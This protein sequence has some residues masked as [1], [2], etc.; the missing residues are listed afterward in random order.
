MLV[1]HNFCRTAPDGE[2]RVLF[3]FLEMEGSYFIYISDVKHVGDFE[4]LHVGMPP[5][6][7]MLLDRKLSHA[8]SSTGG[9]HP[10]N[11]PPCTRSSSLLLA[12]YNFNSQ[13]NDL[14]NKVAGADGCDAPL[15]EKELGASLAKLSV[16]DET[17]EQDGLVLVEM[18]KQNAQQEGTSTSAA[19][20]SIQAEVFPQP[21]SCLMGSL[22]GQG[23]NLASQLAL[24]HAKV[25]HVSCNL[26]FPSIESEEYAD[27][28]LFL[29]AECR[30]FLKQREAERTCDIKAATV[31]VAGEAETQVDAQSTNG[32]E[33]E[34][35]RMSNSTYVHVEHLLDE[36]FSDEDTP[37]PDCFSVS[38][39]PAFSFPSLPLPGSDGE[40]EW[41]PLQIEESRSGKDGDHVKVNEDGGTAHEGAKQKTASASCS[42]SMPPEDAATAGSGGG[43]LA[44][45]SKTAES[46][47]LHLRKLRKRIVT[48]S[49]HAELRSA[50]EAHE[51]A[52]RA[53]T[54]PAAES[55][56]SLAASSRPAAPSKD[57]DAESAAAEPQL[58]S[59]CPT[60]AEILAPPSDR[61]GDEAKFVIEAP[62]VLRVANAE[63]QACKPEREREPSK[64]RGEDRRAALH[65]VIAELEAEEQKLCTAHTRLSDCLRRPEKLYEVCKRAWRQEATAR[66]SSKKRKKP[67][68]EKDLEAEKDDKGKLA[69]V[70]NLRRA[71]NSILEDVFFGLDVSDFLLTEDDG[72]H[73][74]L[75]HGEQGG[76]WSALNFEQ[77]APPS[78]GPITSESVVG[79]SAQQ[80][81]DTPVVATLWPGLPAHQRVA[82]GRTKRINDGDEQEVGAENHR[83]EYQ[84]RAPPRTSGEVETARAKKAARDKV[85]REMM[86]KF[87]ATLKDEGKK[88]PSS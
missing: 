12:P 17:N 85:A 54:Q 44:P 31:V 41:L 70:E 48:Q 64:K 19:A 73:F 37:Y 5:R 3:H 22:D 2:T 86:E 27:L 36:D 28:Q 35:S 56:S 74:K 15:C 53:K 76:P 16:H 40:R 49:Y 66:K 61:D 52:S 55:F 30:A 21:S 4:D 24:H 7:V 47:K 88:G 13:L 33:A 8:S 20:S 60:A 62:M 25:M 29:L 84:G 32:D 63:R 72:H 39:P 10:M 69:G 34:A 14:P 83:R 75:V 42:A 38:A 82:A 18:K 45:A 6:E 59:F 71:L 46:E 80:G 77:L 65:A 87:R 67:A 58:S 23:G 1:P 51:A 11:T 68:K 50:F 43:G 81:P 79:R 9:D 26:N 78:G 57:A